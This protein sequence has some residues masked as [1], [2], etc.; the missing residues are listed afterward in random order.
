M[1]QRKLSKPQGYIVQGIA[2]N[3]ATLQEKANE[4]QA[5]LASYADL[6]REHFDL[7][8]GETQLAPGPD[9]WSLVVRPTPA[10]P[11]PAPGESEPEA[12]VGA[13][14]ELPPSVAEAA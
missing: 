7:P 8:E 10:D 12:E 2:T 1:I 14:D 9:G 5:A 3:L 6:L 4:E 13:D 11:E